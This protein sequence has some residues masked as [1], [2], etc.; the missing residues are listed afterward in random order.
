M[1]NYGGALVGVLPQYRQAALDLVPDLHDRDRRAETVG[2]DSDGNTLGI[3]FTSDEGVILAIAMLPIAAMDESDHRCVII[4]CTEEIKTVALARAVRLVKHGV[5]GQ[6]V[7]HRQR[8]PPLDVLYVSLEMLLDFVGLDCI[9]C[10]GGHTRI[11]TGKLSYMLPKPKEP[12]CNDVTCS[13]LLLE[14]TR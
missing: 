13:R 6:A 4:R 8:L 3:Q 14:R 1:A 10:H 12:C 5:G 9:E 11:S 2:G 7:S